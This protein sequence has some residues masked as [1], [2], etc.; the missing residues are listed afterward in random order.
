MK[1]DLIDRYIY[2]ATRW[3]GKKDREDVSLELRGLIDDLLTERCGDRAP[4]EQDIRFVLTELGSPQEPQEK[5]DPNAGK[6]L[7]GAPYYNTYLFILKIV[8]GCVA[9][10]M[11]VSGGIIAVTEGLVWYEAFFH[12]L[13]LLWNGLLSAFAILTILF[14]V[15][16]RK[17]ISLG[18]PY[19]FDNL[20]PVPKKRQA[21][22]TGECAFGIVISLAFLLVFLFVPQVFSVIL[23]ESKTM[24]PIFDPAA[25]Q[26]R[27]YIIVL[28]SLLGILRDT[29][30]LLERR[31]NQKVLIT[32]VACDLLSA[33]TAFWWLGGSNL[34]THEFTTFMTNLFSS[35]SA[36][37]ARI[38]GQ[39]QH[40]FLGCVLLA[41][42]VDA[43]DAV[44]RTDT[45]NP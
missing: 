18:E 36:L 5:Y 30:K 37:L 34:L 42:T 7:I 23:P 40:F 43:I 13:G 21:I 33:L 39:F 10:G 17:A 45:R 35:E 38:M 20:P 41:L 29:V 24:I 27:W 44:V 31:H 19:N 15:L 9:L 8:L 1:H 4:T 25:I 14:A 3:L 28:F 22:S 16:Y 12:W 6:C 2:A 26:S 32:T 11:T